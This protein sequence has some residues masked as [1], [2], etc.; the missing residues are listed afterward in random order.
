V[1]FLLSPAGLY[2]SISAACSGY[3]HSKQHVRVLGVVVSADFSFDEHVTNVNA[4]CFCHHRRLQHVWR[5]LT[6]ESAAT[7]VHA[8][9]T[10]RVDFCNVVLAGAPKVITNKLQRVMNAAAC[11]LTGTKKFSPR[12]DAADA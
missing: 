10:S 3:Y 12:F 11:V 4:T 9:V 5:M 6:T 7:L 1:K 2:L 8:F